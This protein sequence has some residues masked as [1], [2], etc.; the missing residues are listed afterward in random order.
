VA[1]SDKVRLFV[2]IFPPESVIQRL[3][4]TIR[5]LA[6]TLPKKA[7]AWSSPEQIHL[8][9]NFLGGT[10][11]DR[12]PDLERALAEV[13][14]FAKCHYLEA[15]GLGCFP[16][17]RRPRVVWAGL[18]DPSGALLSLKNKLDERLTELGYAKEERTFQPHLTIGRVKELDAAMRLDVTPAVKE[19]RE[20]SFGRWTVSQ[21]DLMQSVLS[22]HGALYSVVKSFPL[23]S[24]L[25]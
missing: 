25:P 16:T 18:A 17:P 2:A 15:A 3:M 4:E 6:E 1:A 23:S 5:T 19:I 9:L 8:T 7:I 11:R 10:P 14:S 21:V 24:T 22:P 12:I 20:R 13:C